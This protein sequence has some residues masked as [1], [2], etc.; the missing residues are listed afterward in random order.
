M[1]DAVGI[2]QA[3]FDYIMKR[4]RKVMRKRY[5]KGWSL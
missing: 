4:I 2:D 5:P 3:G 1:R